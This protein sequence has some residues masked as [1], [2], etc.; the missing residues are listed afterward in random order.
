MVGL[1]AW[2]FFI[3]LINSI[4]PSKVSKIDKND[5]IHRIDRIDK[6]VVLMSIIF[7]LVV[8]MY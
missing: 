6:K 4:K 5:R 3:R 7:Y 2:L 1:T 8:Y